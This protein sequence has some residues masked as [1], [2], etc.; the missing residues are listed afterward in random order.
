MSE[1]SFI[2]ISERAYKYIRQFT[3]KTIDDALVEVITNSIDA[4]NKTQYVEKYIYI[5]IYDQ[6]TIRVTDHALGLTSEGLQQCFLQL[7]SFTSSDSSRGFFSRGAKDISALGDVIFDTIKDGK[8]SQCVLNTDAYGMITISDIPATSEHRIQHN[9][10]EPLNGL[11]VT[12]KLLP[13]FQ[14]IDINNLYDICCKLGVLR[15][16]N[17]NPQNYIYLRKYTGDAKTEIFN[18]RINYTYPNS[19]LLLDVEYT[20]PNYPEESA[21]LV[22]YQSDT[23]LPQPI[24]ESSLE[25][26]FLIKD[27]TSVYE[28]NT[29][30]DRFRWNPYMNHIYGYIKCDAIKKYLLDYDTNGPSIKNPYPVIDPSRLTGVNKLHP[31]IIDIYS[32]PLL[33]IDLI[34]RELNK[35]VSSKSI[36]IEDIDDILEELGKY[37]LDIVEKEDVQVNFLP[38]YDGN[39]IK[40]INES[41]ADTVTYEKNYLLTGDYNTEEQQIE[42]YINEQVIKLQNTSD[43]YYYS[44][45]TNQLVQ[46]QNVSSDDLNDPINILDLLPTDQVNDLQNHPFI[47]KLGSDGTVHRLYVFQKGVLDFIKND[48]DPSVIL[49]KRQLT[50]EFINDLNI[51]ERYIIDNT[52]GIAIK[53]NLNNP[54]IKKYLV[55]TKT[56]VSEISDIFRL[57]QISSTQSLVF[58]KELMTDVLSDLILE[59]D[60]T[61]SKIVLDSNSYNNTKKIIEHRNK[62]VTK[63][64]IPINNIF[65]RYIGNNINNKVTNVIGA[66]NNIGN[67][68]ITKYGTDESIDDLTLLKNSF[69]DLINS[70]IE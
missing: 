14:S 40:A 8:Y 7:G 45:E 32:L 1:F 12:L 39:L 48:L 53:L 41:R 27:S 47:Y 52:N 59:H 28:I 63:L 19:Q 67:T 31:L 4:Y 57:A 38:T 61:N 43:L 51:Q 33:R 21:K 64:E 11:S 18:R 36:T 65:D 42:N 50:I 13:N 16:I 24:K 55:S 34:L 66:V 62:I 6:H 5:D 49:K 2:N 25:F 9:I 46:L 3:I 23:G 22:I 69:I 44:G 15:D 60:I 37:S 35:S 68:I 10:P 56:D 17:T 58:L 54:I 26:G 20:L 29:V 70:V 30:S